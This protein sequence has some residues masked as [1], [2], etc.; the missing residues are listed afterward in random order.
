MTTLFSRRCFL[1]RTLISRVISRACIAGCGLKHKQLFILSLAAVSATRDLA[2]K[3]WQPAIQPRTRMV[4]SFSAPGSHIQL[5]KLVEGEQHLLLPS[6]DLFIHSPRIHSTE[7]ICVEKQQFFPNTITFLSN[8]SSSLLLIFLLTTRACYPSPIMLKYLLA[9]LLLNQGTPFASAGTLPA[10]LIPRACT[11]RY[12]TNFYAISSQNPDS[13][14]DYGP[15]VSG[16][17]NYF[18]FRFSQTGNGK[19]LQSEA[20]LVATYT[21]VPCGQGP[22][23]LEFLFE[24]ISDYDYGGN[25]N[26]DIFAITGKLPRNS[27]GGGIP[28]WNNL[29]TKMGSL[30]G[31]FEMPQGEDQVHRVFSIG[32]VACKAELNFRVSISNKGFLTGSVGY[33]QNYYPYAES[34]L[35]IQ[36][37]C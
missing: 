10:F 9:L 13:T 16:T 37:G 15:H 19:A 34:G 27:T 18:D 1:N 30:I 32:Q 4:V 22:I 29:K 5:L 26:V 7:S 6:S 11:A 35:R 23:L 17:Y 21:K 20:D 12:P 28:T 14:E 36:Y 24:P 2:C 8:F 31:S 33:S 25:T 3:G